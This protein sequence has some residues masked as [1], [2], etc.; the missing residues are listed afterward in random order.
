LT[1]LRLKL[2]KQARSSNNAGD[3]VCNYSMYVILDH[4]KRHRLSIPHGF[5]HIPCRYDPIK[6]IRVLEKA[7]GRINPVSLVR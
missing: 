3:Y 1:N 6:A 5:I 4:L 7:I 2:G